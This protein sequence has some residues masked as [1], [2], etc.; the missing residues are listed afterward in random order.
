[1]TCRLQ[2]FRFTVDCIF[3]HHTDRLTSVLTHDPRSHDD[4]D[5]SMDH[6]DDKVFDFLISCYVILICCGIYYYDPDNDDNEV[7]E[8]LSHCTLFDGISHDTI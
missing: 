5:D 7:L 1:M 8:L 3:F 6:D 4:K 2:S